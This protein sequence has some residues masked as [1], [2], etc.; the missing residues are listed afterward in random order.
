MCLCTVYIHIYLC[1]LHVVKQE[2]SSCIRYVISFFFS[3]FVLGRGWDYLSV[4]TKNKY[5]HTYTLWS[6]NFTPH[7]KLNKCLHIF[8]KRSIRIT[9]NSNI[10]NHQNLEKVPSSNRMHKYVALYPCNVILYSMRMKW[11][12]MEESHKQYW[13]KEVTYKRIHNVSFHIHKI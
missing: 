1:I 2:H 12:N 7:Y 13:N 5:V 4:F 6:S 10:C 3:F 8:K 11:N 9:H